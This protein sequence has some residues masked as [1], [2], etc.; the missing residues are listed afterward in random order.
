MTKENLREFLRAP[1]IFIEGALKKDQIGI[2]T[3]LA[4]T[5]VGGDILL[6]EAIKIK[7]TGKLILT[8]QLGEV[9]Q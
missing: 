9:M 1:K 3:G 2:V 8:G 4:W 6:I 7:G 5:A